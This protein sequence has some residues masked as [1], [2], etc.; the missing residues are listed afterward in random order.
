MAQIL[1]LYKL[2]TQKHFKH[3]TLF[4]FGKKWCP[5]LGTQNDVTYKTQT[6]TITLS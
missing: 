3:L 5:K 1:T 6:V 2:Y 4:S